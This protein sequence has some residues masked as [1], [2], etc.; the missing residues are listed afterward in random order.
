MKR[1][2]IWLFTTETFFQVC[3]F[4]AF[5]NIA[6]TKNIQLKQKNSTQKNLLRNELF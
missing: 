4:K 5:S 1:H 3:D 2:L 6:D